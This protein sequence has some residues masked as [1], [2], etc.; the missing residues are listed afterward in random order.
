MRNELIGI[1]AEGAE[2]FGVLKS[3]LQAF[4]YDGSEIIPIRPTLN[5]DAHDRFKDT[6]TIGTFQGVKNS[7]LGLDGKRLDFERAF[8]QEGLNFI[9]IQLDTAEIEGQNFNFSRPKKEKNINYCLELRDL[10]I[11]K[12]D[13]WLEHHYKD[14]LFYAI[15]IEELE[16]WCLTIFQEQ[17]T[18]DM[19]NVKGRLTKEL[20]KRNLTYRDLKCHPTN[21]KSMYFEKITQKFKF[22]KLAELKKYAEKNESLK[23]FIQSLES[24]LPKL[25]K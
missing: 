24:K 5:K 1:I 7:C 20:N 4:G 25:D 2:D 19:V 3:I 13:E 22:N 11:T 10:V 15:S 12:I 18:V 9:V 6:Q 16:S 21:E 8:S 17:S 23:Y 14:K